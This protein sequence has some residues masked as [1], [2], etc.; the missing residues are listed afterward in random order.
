MSTTDYV[1]I[2]ISLTI[3]IVCLIDLCRLNI[4]TKQ[5]CF[6]GAVLHIPVL[7]LACYL[8]VRPDLAK[9]KHDQEM[10]NYYS[11]GFYEI[12]NSKLEGLK[13]IRNIIENRA[14]N[15]DK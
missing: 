5:K 9:I 11:Q 7:G 15:D 3:T 10:N 14:N 13:E 8:I 2:F 6:Y 12:Y 1:G 4:S